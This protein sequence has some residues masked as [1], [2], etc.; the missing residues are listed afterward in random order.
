MR[1][2]LQHI[3]QEHRELGVLPILLATSGMTTLVEDLEAITPVVRLF[4]GVYV[5]ATF[6]VSTVCA[7]LPKH[8]VVGMEKYYNFNYCYQVLVCICLFLVFSIQLCP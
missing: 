4:W 3:L 5:V 6:P 2:S 7:T 1:P 8:V